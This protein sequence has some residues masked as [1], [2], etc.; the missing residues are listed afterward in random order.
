[1]LFITNREPKGSIRTKL[2]RSYK[3]DLSK[4]SP[5]NSVYFC[6]NNSEDDSV[7]LG[8]KAFMESIRT[9]QYQQIL[10][11]IHGYNNL[12]KAALQKAVTLQKLFDAKKENFVQV[13]PLIW[14]C[15][16]DFGIIKDYWDDQ[17]AADLSGVSF[18]RVLNKFM[19]W[20]SQKSPEDLCFKRLNIL[21]HS[22]G[23]RVL[24]ETLYAW[25]KYDLSSGVPLIFRNTFL[26]A[27]DIVNESLEKNKK[28][29]LISTA[30]RNVSVY[31]A[32]DDLALRASK[33][34]NLKNKIASRRLGHSGPEDLSKTNKNVF[35]IDCD[36]VNNKYDKPMG[37]TYFD[38]DNNGSAGLVFE[39]LFNSI[40]T[41]RVKL[42]DFERRQHQI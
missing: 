21:A 13:I 27:A 18:A 15:D 24:R 41:G 38:V 10:F 6:K 16:N 22:M 19:N 35:A 30:S 11:F 12:P 20:Q 8:H 32:S 25:D 34:S 2:N 31:Y 39:H 28:G 42:D 37:H 9:N 23:N 36:S 1:M 7:E 3:F 29:N 17:K 14:P 33:I 26:M 5:S 4:N 40:D